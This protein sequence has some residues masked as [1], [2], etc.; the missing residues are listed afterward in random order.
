MQKGRSLACQGIIREGAQQGML[1][2]AAGPQAVAP[3]SA[4]PLMA[5]L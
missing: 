5:R 3:G 4:N 2:V 1:L